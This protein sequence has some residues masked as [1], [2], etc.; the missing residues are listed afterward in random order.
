MHP[1]LR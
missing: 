1:P